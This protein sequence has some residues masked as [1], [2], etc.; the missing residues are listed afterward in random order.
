MTELAVIGN[1]TRDVVAGATARPGGA[2]FYSARAL[3]RLGA[4]ASVAVSCGRDDWAVLAP[5]VERFP[6]PVAW[7]ESPTTTAYSFH[8]EGDQRVMHEEAIGGF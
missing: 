5:Y 7:Y 4:D 8:Y 3:A 1:L 2:V 6:L